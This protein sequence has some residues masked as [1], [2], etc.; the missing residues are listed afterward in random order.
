VEQ[1]AYFTLGRREEGRQA[2]E[3]AAQIDPTNGRNWL[4][5]ADQRR[6]AGDLDGAAEALARGRDDPSPE[7]VAEA[8]VVSGMLDLARGNTAAALEKFREAQRLNPEHAQAYLFEA[9]ARRAAGD[10]AAAKDA[11]RRG[12]A[13]LPGDRKVAAALAALG[14]AP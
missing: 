7:L 6:V 2:L 11:L 5:L 4:M 1:G 8:A 10:V 3:R 9:D 12:L 13:A 14:G